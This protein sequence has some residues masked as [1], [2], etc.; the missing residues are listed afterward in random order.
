MQLNV[1]VPRERESTVR[2]LERAVRT[3]GRSKNLMV[4]DAIEQYLASE[5]E[6]PPTRKPRT[7][8][9]GIRPWT[10]ADI[11]EERMDHIM[12]HDQPQVAEDRATYDDADK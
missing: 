10:R 3:S 8:K 2:A 4:L 11:Y 9:L 1:Y 12:R 7:F 5:Q 6:A